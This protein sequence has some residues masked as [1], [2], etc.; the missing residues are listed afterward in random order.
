MAN[1]KRAGVGKAAVKRRR[2]A[3][4]EVDDGEEH[5]VDGAAAG[6][7]ADAPA[8]P[9]DHDSSGATSSD[10]G[11]SS[12]ASYEPTGYSSDDFDP[13]HLNDFSATAPTPPDSSDDEAP[14]ATTRK[15][16]RRPRI[17]TTDQTT[18]RVGCPFPDCEAMVAVFQQTGGMHTRNHIDQLTKAGKAV[19]ASCTSFLDT[20]FPQECGS[21]GGRFKLG[22]GLKLH[23]AKGCKQTKTGGKRSTKSSTAASVA[24]GEAAAVNTADVEEGEPTTTTREPPKTVGEWTQRAA[25]SIAGYSAADGPAKSAKIAAFL[26]TG[27]Q[28][29]KGNK[30]SAT[31]HHVDADELGLDGTE[32]V[33]VTDPEK[34]ME[35]RV[36]RAGTYLSLGKPDKAKNVLLATAPAKATPANIAK[37]EA[38]HPT[39]SDPTLTLP[40]A[41]VLEESKTHIPEI[42]MHMLKDYLSTRCKTSAGGPSGWTFS[43]LTKMMEEQPHTANEVLAIVR[44]IIHGNVTGDVL[45]TLRTAR[46]LAFKKDPAG[47]GLRP[48]AVGEVLVRI[49]AG[50]MVNACKAGINAFLSPSQFGSP[51]RAGGA[52]AGVHFAR[53][54]LRKRLK[55]ILILLDVKNAFNSVAR[56]AILK[57]VA[58]H[59]PQLLALVTLLYGVESDLSLIHI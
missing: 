29:P 8:P 50:I 3:G 22:T 39:P 46:L 53:S 5:P 7:D 25:G 40:T 57:A 26:A 54:Y 24:P 56:Q 43:M 47:V 21:C 9:V 51:G 15:A 14:A 27:S 11:S 16:A 4:M 18:F 48:I 33:E 31:T 44:D 49:A 42:T 59:F 52:E 17:T 41:A 45:K 38:L 19:P 37:M 35:Q 20:Y 6:R 34:S 30:A 36:Q 28:C 10:S 2:R 55:E 23:Q 13:A 58:K 12:S 1:T 32:P